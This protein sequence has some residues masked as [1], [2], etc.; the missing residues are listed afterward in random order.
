MKLSINLNKLT[1][2]PDELLSTK[3]EKENLPS[4]FGA[5]ILPIIKSKRIFEDIEIL[6]PNGSVPKELT[7]DIDLN[8]IT[9][10]KCPAVVDNKVITFEGFTKIIKSSEVEVKKYVD[11]CVKCSTCKFTNVCNMLTQNTLKSASLLK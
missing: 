2:T 8:N 11:Q 9:D 1:P 5:M 7:I 10:N 3:L 6:V 4:C